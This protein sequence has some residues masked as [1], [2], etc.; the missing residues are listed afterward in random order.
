MS[1][2]WADGH[3]EVIADGSHYATRSIGET[4]LYS[5]ELFWLR[6]GRIIP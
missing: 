5:L 6:L 2:N 4:P 1:K 3:I